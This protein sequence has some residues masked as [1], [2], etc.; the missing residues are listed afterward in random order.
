MKS[1]VAILLI[2]LPFFA[3]TQNTL[4][5]GGD[6]TVAGIEN[7]N[8]N[9]SVIVFADND[10]GDVKFGTWDIVWLNNKGGEIKKVS[11]KIPDPRGY[12][13]DNRSR[14][15]TVL[16]PDGN[17]FYI[18]LT[19]LADSRAFYFSKN[20]KDEVRSPLIVPGGFPGKIT[21]E[22]VFISNEELIYILRKHESYKQYYVVRMNHDT[23]KVTMKTIDVDGPSYIGGVNGS[24]FYNCLGLNASGQPVFGKI[25]SRKK[26]YRID[27]MLIDENGTPQNS[28]YEGAQE[29]GLNATNR[30]LLSNDGE[31]IFVSQSYLNEL[32]LY[33]VKLDGSLIFKEKHEVADYK[34]YETKYV[35][36][37]N[38]KLFQLPNNQFIYMMS[39]GRAVVSMKFD[40]STGKLVDRSDEMVARYNRGKVNAMAGVFACLFNEEGKK[41]REIGQDKKSKIKAFGN[42][43]YRGLLVLLHPKTKTASVYSAEF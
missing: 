20:G 42:I 37:D 15:K 29:V 38:R 10:Y 3:T 32:C 11:E 18:C 16:S 22:D 25:N 21:L 31:S 35:A 33:H 28:S 41:V 30:L 6:K 9:G 12:N 40:G 34:K 27:I 23:K 4:K 19:G 36:P 8:G 13:T 24:A 26:E 39:L 14:Y 5:L 2:A 43:E 1:L 7:S 17:H